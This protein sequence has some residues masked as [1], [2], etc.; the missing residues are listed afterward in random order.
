MGIWAEIK[1]ALN[2]TVG[3]EKFKS[4]DKMIMGVKGLVSSNNLYAHILNNSITVASG[5]T[6]TIDLIKMMW[7]G[8]VKV[9]ITTYK[10]ADKVASVG[11]SK[12]G[13]QIA[14]SNI[15]EG[16]DINEYIVTFDVGDVISLYTRGTSTSFTV[17]G[18]DLYADIIDVSAFEIL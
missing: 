15:S 2:S 8:S 4:L 11:V 1:R 14:T 5:E 6:K 16:T 7:S 3:T 13:V 12:N 17:K 10:S 18:I 9:A